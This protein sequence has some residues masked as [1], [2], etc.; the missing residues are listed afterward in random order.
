MISIQID[1]LTFNNFINELNYKLDGLREIT[2]PTSKTEI[3]KSVFTISSN[4]FV[5]NVNRKARVNRNLSH[6]YEWNS[7]GINSAR[8]FFLQR[9]Y[10]QYGNL[11][12]GTKF[13]NS[14][15]PVPV[16]SNLL[17]P[18]KNGKRVVSRNIFIKKAEVMESGT[19][20][21]IRAR[22][23]L[24]FWSND[25]LKFIPKGRSVTIRNPGGIGK[26][27]A[28]E[29]EFIQWFTLNLN[30]S[31]QDSN[32]INDLERSIAECLNDNKASSKDVKRTIS[33]VSQK[34]SKNRVI[35]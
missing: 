6:V 9:K 22:K 12:I 32:I 31:I 21:T 3:A 17:K 20:V 19:P 13:K 16:N 4:D 30:K 26:R 11:I 33:M 8:L 2:T 10:V 25:G 18:G 28:Y 24:P 1:R 34:Y 29:K 23:P 5:K 14:T 15:T 35:M 7:A 27:G